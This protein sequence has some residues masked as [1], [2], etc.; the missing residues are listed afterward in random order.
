[1]GTLIVYGG[2]GGGGGG[3]EGGGGEGGEIVIYRCI[4]ANV[5]NNYIYTDDHADEQ[6]DIDSSNDES[7][8]INDDHENSF[9]SISGTSES[10]QEVF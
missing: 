10:E 4:I 8:S 1:M 5:C 6:N 7:V 2:G 3:G 9:H